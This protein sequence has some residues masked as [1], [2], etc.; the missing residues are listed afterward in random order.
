MA[1]I[2]IEAWLPDELLQPF[3]QH[4]RDFE[5]SHSKEMHANMLVTD[6]GTLSM[7]DVYAAAIDTI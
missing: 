5:S 3:L 6:L 4:I 2:E 7:N 1:K